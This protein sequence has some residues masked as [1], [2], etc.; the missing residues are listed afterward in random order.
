MHTVKQIT[1][2]LIIVFLGLLFSGFYWYTYTP[3]ELTF[4]D[5]AHFAVIARQIIRHQQ[6][7]TQFSFFNHSA[8]QRSAAN[9]PFPASILPLTPLTIAVSFVL[10]G[11]SDVGAILPSMFFFA[12]TGLL[13]FI[14][15]RRYSGPVSAWISVLI[16]FTSLPFLDYAT[17][18]ASESLF[19]FLVLL[20]FYFFTAKYRYSVPCFLV[21]LF[22]TFLTRQHA[23]IYALGFWVVFMIINRHHRRLLTYT[24]LSPIILLLLWWVLFR[25]Q[26][27]E[28]YLVRLLP[29]NQLYVILVNTPLIPANTSLRLGESIFSLSI[30]ANLSIV[31]S[32]LF[33]N[34]YNL[35][36]LLPNIYPPFLIPFAVTSIFLPRVDRKL[37]LFLLSSFTI[38]LIIVALS[39]PS[40]RYL[41]P[42]LPFVILSGISAFT[43]LTQKIKLAPALASGLFLLIPLFSLLIDT[44]FVRQTHN[45]QKPSAVKILAQHLA[46]LTPPDSVTITN[47]DVWGSWFGDRTTIWFPLEPS[48]IASVAANI[49]HNPI[50]YIYLVSYK[51]NDENY[52]VG[53]SWSSLLQ[54]PATISDDYLRNNYD[55]LRQFDISAADNYQ[56][57]IV[58]ATLLKRK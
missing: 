16:F 25:T 10:F 36:K 28:N 53:L 5:G 26:G 50:D 19:T 12:M 3:R 4:S 13:I 37:K 43:H 45:S 11:I 54:K 46:A 47:L 56:N 41:H 2:A 6:F 7:Y 57:Q 22:L 42:L 8:L 29:L 23:F 49:D 51:A 27:T 52:H 33:Y 30:I 9:L 17:S 31:A 38:N 15:A 24:L 39:V 35:L 20:S 55:L 48:Q 34:S 14:L 40:Y 44:R 58:T 1:I 18:A 32:K 21:S